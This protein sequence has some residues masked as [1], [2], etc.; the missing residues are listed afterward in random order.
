MNAYLDSE[1]FTTDIGVAQAH[2]FEF[3]K[4]KFS[5]VNHKLVL[6][7]RHLLD[8]SRIVVKH[9]EFDDDSNIEEIDVPI[10]VVSRASLGVE[11]IVKPQP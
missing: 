5:K 10:E 7:V 3:T 2:R 4:K 11:N 8:F 9:G 6:P 1:N